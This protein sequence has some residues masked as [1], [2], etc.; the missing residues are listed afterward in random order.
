MTS[1]AIE[2]ARF[3][4]SSR[5]DN[6]GSCVE[7][8]DDSVPIHAIVPVRDCQDIGGPVLAVDTN[9]WKYFA[10]NSVV[11]PSDRAEAI[12]PDPGE[13]RGTAWFDLDESVDWSAAHFD[14]HM[15]RFVT[16][17]SAALVTSAS[18]R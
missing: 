18:A 1:E 15:A 12:T 10:D 13:F 16:K 8:A 9:S 2:S 4:K 3:R 6:S 5:S 17:L 14:P 7:V 11:V